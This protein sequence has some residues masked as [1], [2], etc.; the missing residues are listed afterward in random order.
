[1]KST[2]VFSGAMLIVS[3]LCVSGS[4]LDAVSGVTVDD[5]EARTFTSPKGDTIQYRLFVPRDYKPVNSRGHVREN[6]PG[7]KGRPRIPALSS[8]HRYRGENRGTGKIDSP[9]RK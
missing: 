1:M 2:V 8:P 3:A 5:Y 7:P 4:V 9:G 6:G